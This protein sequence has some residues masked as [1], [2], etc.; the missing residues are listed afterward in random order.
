MRRPRSRPCHTRAIRII[1]LAVPHTSNLAFASASE[2]ASI[3]TPRH[4]FA[5]AV[6]FA[7]TFASASPR[8]HSH[9]HPRARALPTP[10]VHA[11]RSHE[12]HAQQ[13]PCMRTDR[14]ACR[15]TCAHADASWDTAST[16]HACFHAHGRMRACSRTSIA[17]RRA[18]RYR[19]AHVATG[20]SRRTQGES[21]PR[22]RR[23]QRK[24]MRV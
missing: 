15:Q 24:C 12:I 19:F 3:C 7:F 2:P 21:K 20:R 13:H 10:L 4:A 17:Q 5:V 16:A 8:P 22:G 6:A 11:C 9:S 18:R 23:E 14:H 1:E